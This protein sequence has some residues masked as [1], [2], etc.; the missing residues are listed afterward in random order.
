MDVT[1]TGTAVIGGD[2]TAKVVA[3]ANTAVPI[4]GLSADNFRLTIN[5]VVDAISGAIV[6][7][8]DGN[9]VITP[10]ATTIITDSIVVQTY[11]AVAVV[12]VAILGDRLYKGTSVAITPA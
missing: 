5:G 1:I 10:T 7:N 4:L 3:T 11:D 12:A 8:G 9:Y 6:D 2:I